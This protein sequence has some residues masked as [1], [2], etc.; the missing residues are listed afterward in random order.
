MKLQKISEQKSGNNFVGIL[1]EVFGP[2][3]HS[4]INWPL[5]GMRQSI[6]II[7]Q[8]FSH[9]GLVFGNFHRYLSILKYFNP[10]NFIFRY[11]WRLLWPL[12][13]SHSRNAS[14]HQNYWTMFEQN[15]RRGYQ[16]R[17][18]KMCTTKPVWNEGRET[19]S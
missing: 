8:F 10:F 2:K 1:E 3:G 18:C 13:D 14:I 6:R 15:A 5:A 17:R 9:Y 7:K 4:E 11:K 16:H 12:F 19:K